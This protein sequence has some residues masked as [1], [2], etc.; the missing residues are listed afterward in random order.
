L[1]LV[2][3]ADF[4]YWNQKYWLFFIL[5]VLAILVSGHIGYIGIG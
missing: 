2:S 3:A 5:V 1:A 4:W